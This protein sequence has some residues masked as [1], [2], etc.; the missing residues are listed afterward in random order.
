[1][2]WGYRLRGNIESMCWLWDWWRMLVLSGQGVGMVIILC[3]TPF[4]P[5]QSYCK[6]THVFAGTAHLIFL[7]FP[8]NV[9]PWSESCFLDIRQQGSVINWEALA[10]QWPLHCPWGCLPRRPQVISSLALAWRCVHW[11]CLMVEARLCQANGRRL[12]CCIFL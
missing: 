7:C 9:C 5:L 1:M 10:G 11:F 2:Q 6:Y 3:M 4:V 8:S 12:L